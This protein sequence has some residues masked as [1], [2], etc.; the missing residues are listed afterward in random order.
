MTIRALHQLGSI[1]LLALALAAPS[2]AGPPAAIPDGGRERAGRAFETFANE[3]MAKME[4]AERQNR[5]RP[6]ASAGS[7]TYRGYASEF[8]TELKP[9]GHPAA[10]YVG[11]LRYREQLYSCSDKAAKDC[12]VATQTPVTEIFRFQN[13]RWVY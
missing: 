2:L 9:T 11:L 7:F 5:S 1:G 13:G 12:S 8:E 10:P 4:R 6:K 3:W